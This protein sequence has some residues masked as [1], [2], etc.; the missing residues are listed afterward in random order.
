MFNHQIASTIQVEGSELDKEI[1]GASTKDSFVLTAIE[2][3]NPDYREGYLWFK[4][5]IY[6]PVK[7]QNAVLEELHDSKVCRHFGREKTLARLKCWYF[8]PHMRKSVEEFIDKCDV[9]KQTKHERHQPYRKLRLQDLKGRPWASI[10]MDFVV[11]LPLL[12]DP[13]TRVAYDSIMIVTDQ[14]TKYAMFISFK[15]S[16]TAEELAYVFLRWIVSNHGMP[17]EIITDRDKLF[18]SKFWKSLMNQ[19][20]SKHKLSTAFHPQINSQTERLNQT[21]KQYLRC[22]IN[23]K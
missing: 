18:T 23:Y 17:K 12:K 11:K 8:Y 13:A 19:L 5:R 1:K 3:K 20:G 2:D 4:D 22:Y 10:A 15:E 7:I 14:F 9:C 6:L 16:T 21:M